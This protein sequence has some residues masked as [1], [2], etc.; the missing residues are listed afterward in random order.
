[1]KIFT[2]LAAM[3]CLAS[4]ASAH[5][6]KVVREGEGEAVPTPF[7]PVFLL[8]SAEENEGGVTVYEF[9]VPPHSPGSPPHT[10]SQEDEYFFV[11]SGEL[12][13]LS[14]S[15]VLTLQE[16]DFA[17]L[18]R[19]NA[20]MFWNASDAPVRMIMMTTGGSFEQ[21]MASVAPVLAT[22][23]PA[24][25]AEAGAVIGALAAEHGITIS[26]EMMPAEAAALYA[27]D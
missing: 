5:P 19:G 22:A 2:A 17:A 16:G 3:A 9:E 4:T 24:D 7:H 18:N 27:P 12:S 15:E 26:M 6:D 14:G 8:L 23:S 25:A 20:H 11:T 21:F 1:M 10:H 13:V